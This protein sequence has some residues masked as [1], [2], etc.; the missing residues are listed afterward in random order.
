MSKAKYLID[1]HG[2]R[3]AFSTKNNHVRVA[4]IDAIEAGELLIVRSASDELKDIDEP[5]YESFQSS[6]SKKKYIKTASKH[7]ATAASLI[8][9]YGASIFGVSP[10]AAR[11]EA[12]AVCVCE[13]LDLVTSG[14]SHSECKKIVSKCKLSKP[15]VLSVDEFAKL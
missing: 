10:P 13:K 11:F 1:L 9:S 15:K 5:A 6:V 8:N 4:V 12:V 3:E 2:L 14:K 7:E